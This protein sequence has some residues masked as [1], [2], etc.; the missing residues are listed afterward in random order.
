MERVVVIQSVMVRHARFSVKDGANNCEM[1]AA[2]ESLFERAA[3]CITL[4]SKHSESIRESTWAPPDPAREAWRPYLQWRSAPPRSSA[5][6]SSPVAALTCQHEGSD[7][8]TQA[9][10]E[11]SR[12]M[13]GAATHQRG[14]SQEDGSLL[15]HDDAFVGH[16]GDV[17]PSGGARAH[18]NSN[19]TGAEPEG[20]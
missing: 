9:R 8:L 11:D 10:D 1:V 20:V 15:A 3:Y 16:G 18:H 14:S 17:R 13:D 12:R 5:E 7:A 6:T 4:I 2:R 19:L